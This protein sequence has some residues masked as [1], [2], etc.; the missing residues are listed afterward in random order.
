MF[1]EGAVQKEKVVLGSAN[2]RSV[3]LI[4]EFYNINLIYA[5]YLKILG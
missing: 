4:S 3:L 5:S 1:T 2:L